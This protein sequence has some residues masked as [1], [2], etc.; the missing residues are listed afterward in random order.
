VRR[1]KVELG[2]S[3]R[4]RRRRLLWGETAEFRRVTTAFPR[5]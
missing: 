2:A 5:N 1:R 4:I 3:G